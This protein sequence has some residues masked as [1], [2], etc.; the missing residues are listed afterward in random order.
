MS[1]AMH[2]VL[3]KPELIE[4]ILLQLP[5]RGLLVHAQLVNKDFYSVI[6]MGLLFDLVGIAGTQFLLLHDSLR[7]FA[8]TAATHTPLLQQRQHT[9]F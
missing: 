6:K 7:S 1:P 9:L 3:S 5:V 4:L 8:A 2:F